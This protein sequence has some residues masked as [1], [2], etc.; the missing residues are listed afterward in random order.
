MNN[1]R[2]LFTNGLSVLCTCEDR[3]AAQEM[4]IEVAEF[5]HGYSTEIRAIIILY[6]L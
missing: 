3:S 5:I 4:A 1:Y 2:V 6:C